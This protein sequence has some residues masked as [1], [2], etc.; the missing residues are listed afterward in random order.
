[1]DAAAGAGGFCGRADPRRGAVQADWLAD[2][3]ASPERAEELK[4]KATP[5][6]S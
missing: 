6:S 3:L 2:A 5:A 4:K 1:M